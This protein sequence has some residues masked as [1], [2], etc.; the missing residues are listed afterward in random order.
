MILHSS[1]RHYHVITLTF[2]DIQSLAQKDLEQI[3]EHGDFPLTRKIIRRSA[4]NLCLRRYIVQAAKRIENMHAKG[5]EIGFEDIGTM[6]ESSS[7]PSGEEALVSITGSPIRPKHSGPR[8]EQRQENDPLYQ[9]L[10]DEMSIMQNNLASLTQQ[11]E[12]SR[13]KQDKLDAQTV[14]ISGLIMK[15]LDTRESRI[16][17]QP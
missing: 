10:N 6:N 11:I 16:R 5:I 3:M 1:R 13:S 17:L 4:I 7:L 12:Q 8:A 14:A 2:V 15:L 9:N